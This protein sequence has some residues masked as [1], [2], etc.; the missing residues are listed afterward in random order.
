MCLQLVLLEDRVVDRE[1]RAARIAE[2]V[3]DALV[4]H[5]LDHHLG[6]GHL[7]HGSLQRLVSSFSG[8]SDIRATKKA[9]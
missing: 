4:L 8:L 1:H 9:L 2:D 6:A 3:L 5:R 7:G